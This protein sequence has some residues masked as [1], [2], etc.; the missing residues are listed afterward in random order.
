MRREIRDQKWY[1]VSK[2]Q[3]ET[4]FLDP[5]LRPYR[6]QKVYILGLLGPIRA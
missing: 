3:S 4:R 1:F 5:R 2:R 6:P